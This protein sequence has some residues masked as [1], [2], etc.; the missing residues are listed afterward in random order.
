MNSTR[1]SGKESSTDCCK[2]FE[3]QMHRFKVALVQMNAGREI[4]PNIDAASR[5]IR[6]A[7]GAGAELILT[8][9]N[10]SFIEQSRSLI[11]EKARTEP[12]HPAIP[13]FKLLAAETGAWLLIG[14][15]T[16]KLDDRSCANRSFLFSPA[17]EIVA[18]YDKIH[19]FDVDLAD[20]ESYRESA[21]FRPGAKAVVADLP[22]GRLGLSICYD[23]RFAHLYRALAQAGASFLS[24]P[25]AF[26][27]PT[28][29]AHWHVLLRARAIE[30]GCYVFAPAQCGEHA[31]S[32]RTYGHSLVV[33]PWG[34]I[35]A[36][37]GEE[38]GIIMAEIEPAKVE[39]ARRMVP[40]LQHDREFSKP[41]HQRV[42]PRLTAAGE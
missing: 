37:G 17:G 25:A 7:R 22:Y 11:L 13:A 34:E 4:G 9:E 29:R 33:S 5:L 35:I 20:G 6:E 19:M 12:E 14:S 30:T 24:V 32:R 1:S 23:L 28:G 8:P 16:I 41:A 38:P 3:S 39:E 10:T 26:T 42:K 21:T 36:E 31:E 15:L 40:A 18:R 2:E 27:V